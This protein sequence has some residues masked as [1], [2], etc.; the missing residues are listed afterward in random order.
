MVKKKKDY[1]L[2]FFLN[3]DKTDHLISDL[4]KNGFRRSFDHMYIPICESCNLC[5]PSRIN[6]NKFKISK[7][8][9]RNLKINEDLKLIKA[10]KI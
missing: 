7:S 6:L 8:N 2:I 10:S 9:K 1:T 5:I 3:S 4:T